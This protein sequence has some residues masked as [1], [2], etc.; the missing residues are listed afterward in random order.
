MLKK[1]LSN[2]RNSLLTRL[3]SQLIQNNQKGFNVFSIKTSVSSFHS[4]TKNKLNDSIKNKKEFKYFSS[5]SNFI[6]NEEHIKDNIKESILSNVKSESFKVIPIRI[7]EVLMPYGK[8]VKFTVTEDLNYLFKIQKSTNVKFC[9]FLYNKKKNITSNIGVLCSS[10]SIIS[11]NMISLTSD[12]GDCRVFADIDKEDFF[13]LENK[14]K[15]NKEAKDKNSDAVN[16]SLN[17]EA[18]LTDKE[19]NMKYLSDDNDDNDFS[20]NEYLEDEA[21]FKEEAEDDNEPENNID[22]NTESVKTYIREVY[23]YSDESSISQFLADFEVSKNLLTDINKVIFSFYEVATKQQMDTSK[24]R[25]VNNA[26]ILIQNILKINIDFINSL[27][28]KA[29]FTKEDEEEINKILKNKKNFKYNPFNS[30]NFN[31]DNNSKEKETENESDEENIF[32][33]ISKEYENKENEKSLFSLIN[34]DSKEKKKEKVID[35]ND[36]N[37]EG[38]KENSINININNCNND[39]LNKENDSKDENYS[40]NQAY[41]NF[42][43]TINDMNAKLISDY[44][45]G[46]KTTR[47]KFLT[48]INKLL[49]HN[50]QKF[51]KLSTEF[52]K[53]FPYKDA[54]DFLSSKDPIERTKNLTSFVYE[55]GDFVIKDVFMFNE[56]KKDINQKQEK[57]LLRFVKKQ[58]DKYSSSESQDNYFKRLNDLFANNEINEQTKRSIQLEIEQAFNSAISNSENESEDKKKL[59]IVEDI[60]SFP[61]DKRQEVVFDVKYTAEVLNTDLYGLQ[62]VKMRIDEYVAKLK[63]TYN[64]NGKSKN[65]GF[66]I[67]ITGPPGTGKTTVAHLIGK[68]LKR[69]TGLIN[70]SGET[71]TIN[72][73]GSRRTYVDSQPSIFF[74]EMVKLGVKNPVIILDE[75]DKI[76]NKGDKQSHSASSALL[77]L[78]NPEENHNF[79]DQYLNVPLD[80][81]ETIFICTSN[82]NVNLLEPLLDRVEIL[83]IDDYTFKEKKEISERYL[84]PRLL[85]EYGLDYSHNE[86]KNIIDITEDSSNISTISNNENADTSSDITNSKVELIFPSHVVE[87]IIR[88]YTHYSTGCRGIKRSL[89]KIIRKINIDL[90]INLKDLSIKEVNGD[91]VSSNNNKSKININHLP[92]KQ[93]IVDIDLVDKYLSS[94]KTADSNLKKL[95]IESK[96]GYLCSDNYGSI[97]RMIIKQRPIEVLDSKDRDYDKLNK[98]FKNTTLKDIYKNL[99]LLV[100]VSKP[101][102]ESIDTAIDIARK[103][104]SRLI[105]DDIPLEVENLLK[106]YS[107]Y[108][109][110]PYIEKKGNSF[111][112]VFLVS[113]IGNM[114]GFHPIED[115]ILI[116]GELNSKGH[117]LKV[118]NLKYILSSCEY[119]GIKK[120]LL[121]EGK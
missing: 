121:P 50:I 20:D 93:L 21:E 18:L 27:N 80:F 103:E 35:I 75:I 14:Y 65:K 119:Y 70:L 73:K 118:V 4:L 60:F 26:V 68:A 56:Y 11:N 34:K 43:N 57:Y 38:N 22:L 15:E 33:N 58:V 83:E 44:N 86:S 88:D 113:L 84:I 109:T 46:T 42:K 69:K 32:K 7:P 64:N 12:E 104:I 95:I 54:M 36:S 66:V 100:K 89:E 13:L 82:Y 25:E 1:T 110:N 74:K 72:L 47:A 115:N 5:T 85:K 107:L 62:K 77:E 91:N 120:L 117:I 90:F 105:S 79:I 87:E 116:L 8:T 6:N 78:L 59:S 102:K 31:N 24:I 16:A 48:E 67:L 81:S 106:A 97:D 101:V 45:S 9:A 17:K 51:L 99:E 114:F 40:E 92:F 49:F 52:K 2:K 53:Y 55:I 71:D 3:H 23:Q 96:E 111:G 108:I 19:Q 39:E 112:L 76:A 28:N 98:I 61:W 37:K 29:F 94:H 30:N 63:R 41:I 10:M